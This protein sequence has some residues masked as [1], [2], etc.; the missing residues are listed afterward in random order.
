MTTPTD[1]NQPPRLEIVHRQP[2]RPGDRPPLLFVHGSFSGAWLWTEHF[3]DYFA[4]AGY[5]A[6]ALSLRGHGASE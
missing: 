6:Y 1:P 2:Q 4:Q 3:L 5:P